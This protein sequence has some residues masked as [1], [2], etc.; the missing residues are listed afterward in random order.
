ISTRRE[1]AAE[2]IATVKAILDAL[3][4]KYV[5][6]G[7]HGVKLVDRPVGFRVYTASIAG[8]SGFTG[9]F[10]FADEVAKW[11]DSDTGQN[12]ATEVLRSVRPTMLTQPN[13]RIILSSS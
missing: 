7:E 2:R 13:S 3:S 5:P 9:I 4:V 11:K 8:V 1:E 6:W 12:P 10:V